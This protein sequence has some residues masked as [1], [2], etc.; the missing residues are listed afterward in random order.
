MLAGEVVTGGWRRRRSGTRWTCACPAR[1]AAPTARSGSTWPRTR[2]SSCTSHY[3]GRRRP[4]RPLQPGL[5]APLGSRSPPRARARW[6]TP[7]RR[8]GPVGRGRE[9]P[10]AGS[11]RTRDPP[12]ARRGD[13]PRVVAPPPDAGSAAT[14]AHPACCCGPTP[15]PNH[16]SPSVGRAAVQ[17]LEAAGYRVDLA[18]E[19]CVLRPRPGSPPASSTPP[20]ACAAVDRLATWR[21]A[22]ERR[23]ADARTELRW[24][25]AGHGASVLVGL[26]PS[27]A[28]GAAHDLPELLP[29]DPRAARLA[30]RCGRSPRRWTARPGLGSRPIDR[31]GAW[32]RP[33][34]T[35][36]PSSATTPTAT[37]LDR[38]GA[39]GH[40]GGGC[41]GLAG[42]FGFE[43]GHYEVSVACAEDAL[44]PAVRARRPGRGGPGRR[45]LLPD[46]AGPPGRPPGPP[47]GRATRRRPALSASPGLA[48]VGGW[49]RGWP[50]PRSGAGLGAAGRGSSA[51]GPRGGGRGRGAWRSA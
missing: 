28:G 9:A 35:S 18:D 39:D 45:L 1:A 30:A 25:R 20:T 38:A 19:P 23:A 14:R 21:T 7:A 8:P 49:G 31:R 11:T 29:D 12:E 33:T 36:T 16:L 40:R 22:C 44:L 46:P 34:A 15:S 32:A 13:L 27:C 17:V 50:A 47:P 6:S 10:R 41:C 26:E 3:A 42:N 51:P 37:L 4:R 2:R 24:S 48:P 5:A 43:R